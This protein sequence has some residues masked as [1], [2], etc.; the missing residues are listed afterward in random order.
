[1][2][3]VTLLLLLAAACAATPPPDRGPPVPDVLPYS[4]E[5]FWHPLVLDAAATLEDAHRKA[6]L[7]QA[8]ELIHPCDSGADDDGVIS[9]A[10]GQTPKST[11]RPLIEL[12]M[13][14]RT[15]S[16]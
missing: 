7:P 8:V 11:G 13:P 2:K 12:N 15:Q 6:Q 16:I 9:I 1:M 4:G 14:N 3:R 10:R 5:D